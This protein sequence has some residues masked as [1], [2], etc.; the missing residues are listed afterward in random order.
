MFSA[1]ESIRILNLP[2]RSDR[3]REMLAELAK[4]GLADDE[5][6]SFFSGSTRTD[7]GPFSSAGEHGCFSSVGGSSTGIAGGMYSK[8]GGSKTSGG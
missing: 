6:V 7:P 8:D 1:F 5:R 4:F 3:R 2:H